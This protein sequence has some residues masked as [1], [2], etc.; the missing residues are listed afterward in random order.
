ML[1][2]ALVGEIRMW[3]ADFAPAKWALCDGR[4]LST[5]EMLFNLIGTTFGGDGMENFALPDLRGRA[6]VH[7]GAG[8][9]LPGIGLGQPVGRENASISL[10]Q[11]PSHNHT[12]NA[13]STE[14]NTNIPTNN[15]IADSGKEDPD[16]AKS[17]ET[18]TAIM[19]NQSLSPVGGNQP[20]NIMQPSLGI[21][22]IICLEGIWPSKH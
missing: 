20:Y 16:F 14:G 18:P 8:P 9:G 1:T 4:L 3:S 2:D 22:F 13:Q 17:S 7:F 5:Q 15:T 12:L 11:M 19:G 10:Q 21:N 6:P